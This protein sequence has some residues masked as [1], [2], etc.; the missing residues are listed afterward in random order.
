MAAIAITLFGPVAVRAVGTDAPVGLIRSGLT[1]LVYLALGAGTPQPRESIITDLWPDSAPDRARGRLATVL[2]R[3]RADLGRIGAEAAVEVRDQ[4]LGLDAETTAQVDLTR[5]EAR[6]RAFL[7]AAPAPADI[8]GW[9]TALD[10]DCARGEAMAGWFDPWAL[11]A[12][13]RIED[14][15]ERCLGR[16]MELAYAAGLDGETQEMAERLLALDP[17]REDVHQVLIRLHLRRGQRSLARRQ[18]ERCRAVLAAELGVAPCAETL[19]LI[20]PPAA[21]R[22]PGDPAA[23]RGPN[24]MASLRAA[25]D[26]AQAGLA[27][28]RRELDSL[29]RS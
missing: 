10:A 4:T 7:T 29:G 19:A 17:L 9:R 22:G 16:V 2:W 14:L 20:A 5:F 13:V 27:R 18:F 26:E 6:A 15:R 8:V 1:L 21:A 3:L 11:R 12:R 23:P 25:I 28:L 24:D